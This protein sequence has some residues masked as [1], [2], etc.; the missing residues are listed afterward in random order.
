MT[1]AWIA[2]SAWGSAVDLLRGENRAMRIRRILLGA[3]FV[4][5]MSA[6]TMAAT[7]AVASADAWDCSFYLLFEGYG[8]KIVDIG[9]NFGSQG[10]QVICLGSLQIAGVPDGIAEEACRRAALLP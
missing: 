6:A 7:P 2:A 10:N 1:I 5:G 3:A 8:G 9:C 4:A